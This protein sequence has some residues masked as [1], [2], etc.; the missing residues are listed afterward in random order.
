MN[1]TRVLIVDDN[2][3]EGFSIA[4]AL[5]N[6]GFSP[7]FVRYA[8]E[9]FTNDTHGKHEGVWCFIM[10]IDLLGSGLAN[11]DGNTAFAAVEGA[12]DYLLDD[13]NGPYVLVTWSRHDDRAEE[14]F[15]HLRERLPIKKRPFILLRLEKESFLNSEN[16]SEL[17]TKLLQKLGEIPPL[18]VMMKWENAV[19]SSSCDITQMLFDAAGV[20]EPEEIWRENLRHILHSL[21]QSH[22]GKTLCPEN[23][24]SSLYSVLGPLLEDRILAS[25]NSDL[26]ID[27]SQSASSAGSNTN[28]NWWREI[29]S[30]LHLDSNPNPKDG[31]G[32]VYEFPGTESGLPSPLDGLGNRA[33]FVRKYFLLEQNNGLRYERGSGPA[34]SDCVP[35]IVDVTP[36][37]DHSQ[38]K[39]G[40]R[41]FIGGIRV[42]LTIPQGRER[43]CCLKKR[44]DYLK[45]T[46]EF[47]KNE[48]SVKPFSL[49][50]NARLAI[51]LSDDEAVLLRLGS[52]KFRVRSQLIGDII[53]WLSQYAARP[54]IVSL[55]GG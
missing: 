40:L 30:M 22:A 10:D 43:E 29:N 1:K 37:C 38:E 25:L 8:Q 48:G 19:R 54:G 24:Q 34:E 53:S 32:L 12:I 44:P 47:H 33:D 46:P 26:P 52:P 4:L 50:I 27:L 31:T 16:S 9:N 41:K 2:E 5:H 7:W 28:G 14:L 42:D 3:K 20:S 51:S 35:I 39:A 23:T 21:A 13:N 45:M 17:Q 6:H 15:Q 55:G 11:S 49:V 36:P 18:L